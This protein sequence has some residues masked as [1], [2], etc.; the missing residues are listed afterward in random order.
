M[1]DNIDIKKGDIFYVHLG[2]DRN[3]HVQHGGRDGV[4]PCIIVNNNVACV[5]SPVL[6]V[7]PISSSVANR[8]RNLPTHLPLG[9]TLKKDSVALFEQ[10]LTINRSQLRNKIAT[11][12][13]NLM[14]L[15]DDMLKVSFGIPRTA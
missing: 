3:G 10:I 2:K 13:D 4:R 15:A 6:L 14:Q 9:R 1:T 8:M 7:V 12:P 5:F 11:L